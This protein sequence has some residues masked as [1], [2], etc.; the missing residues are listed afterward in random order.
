MKSTSIR[1]L[2]MGLSL[3]FAEMVHAQ[4]ACPP[5][6]TPYGTGQDQSVCGPDNSQQQPAQRQ[7]RPQPQ[8]LQPIWIDKYGAIA[9]DLTHGR[10]GAGAS[11]NESNRNEAEKA[12]ITNCQ[13]NGGTSACHVEIWYVNQCVALVGG[14]TS[15][16]AEAGLTIDLATQAA[17]KVCNA[18]DTHCQVTYTAC[19]PP[20]RIQ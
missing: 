4:A 6:M 17:M 10:N 12:A 3:L 16:N 2:L 7:S 5:G 11:V 14:A 1:G 20:V 18:A 19:S 13:D 15:H 8:A 9:T